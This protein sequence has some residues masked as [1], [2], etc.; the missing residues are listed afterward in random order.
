MKEQQGRPD[1]GGKDG[2]GDSQ[3]HREIVTNR[4][5]LI[6]AIRIGKHLLAARGGVRRDVRK[7]ECSFRKPDS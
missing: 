7:P 1:E 2:Q 5:F 6:V 4:D 3:L